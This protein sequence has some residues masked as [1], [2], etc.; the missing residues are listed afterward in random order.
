MYIPKSSKGMRKNL[1]IQQSSTSPQITVSN[2]QEDLSGTE[3]AYTCEPNAS[4]VVYEITT[5]WHSDPD[6]P[7]SYFFLELWEKIGD[8]WSALGTG[9]R[10]SEIFQY[11][12]GQDLIVCS[13][14]I[15]PYSG[16][17]SY[18]LRVR[19]FSGSARRVTLH[20]DE[21]G[22]SFDPIVKIYSVL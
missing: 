13:I 17:R 21:D 3:I 1:T 16:E 7:H 4:F 19:S 11:L 14:R 6:L 20:E 8:T 2:A 22:N 9:Y 18:K 10:W 12:D 5:Q 15:P